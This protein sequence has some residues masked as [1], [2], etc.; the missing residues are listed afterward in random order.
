MPNIAANKLTG[1]LKMRL[2][3]VAKEALQSGLRIS[4]DRQPIPTEIANRIR[5]RLSREDASMHL[6]VAE[7]QAP[8][9]W[10]HHHL[11]S[12]NDQKLLSDAAAIIPASVAMELRQFKTKQEQKGRRL[13]LGDNVGL[14]SELGLLSQTLQILRTVFSQQGA[15]LDDPTAL[16]QEEFNATVCD[17]YCLA[18]RAVPRALTESVADIV[19]FIA[20]KPAEE[21]I[22]LAA[23]A[24]ELKLTDDLMMI[25]ARH[26]DGRIQDIE[27]AISPAQ[28]LRLWAWAEF[29]KALLTGKDYD[30]ALP[31]LNN[32]TIPGL[33]NAYL[34]EDL[35]EE[36]VAEI[37]KSPSQP[38]PEQRQVVQRPVTAQASPPKLLLRQ[39]QQNQAVQASASDQVSPSKPALLIPRNGVPIGQIAKALEIPLEVLLKAVGDIGSNRNSPTH[40]L[41]ARHWLKVR[42]LLISQGVISHEQQAHLIVS[43]PQ[44]QPG[45]DGGQVISMA[46]HRSAK[47]AAAPRTF[48]ID[49]LNICRLTRPSSLVTLL[50]LAVE[51]L[52]RGDDFICIFDASA[53]WELGTKRADKKDIPNPLYDKLVRK[54]PQYFLQTPRGEEA[55]VYLLNVADDIHSIISNDSFKDYADQFKWLK[56][57]AQ[58]RQRLIGSMVVRAELIIQSLKIR[59]KISGSADEVFKRFEELVAAKSQLAAQTEN[60][61]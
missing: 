54:Y 23:L 59:R 8:R 41:K 42:D 57:S 43:N 12:I 2:R 32:R 40:H 19:E 17:L 22:E 7:L 25:A 29:T 47:G 55:D 13:H 46:D 26:F 60:A 52:E 37:G 34:G 24:E 35:A 38:Q 31:A 4:N 49:G 9:S 15:D 58:L 10:I 36:L 45:P 51:L 33:L 48:V 21:K 44:G 5:S 1:E 16:E 53:R 14:A 11:A 27:S 30:E 18:H 56:D 3:M 20:S 28:A 6:L 61:S 39:P 50:V